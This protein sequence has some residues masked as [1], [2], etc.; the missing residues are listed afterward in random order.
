MNEPNL[1]TLPT[2]VCKENVMVDVDW[3]VLEW[4]KNF[5]A[6]MQDIYDDFDRWYHNNFE[7][8][9]KERGQIHESIIRYFIRKEI[10]G[11]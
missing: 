4:K 5:E 2:E 11:V 10:L 7:E 8:I 1:S 6:K 9:A 3:E